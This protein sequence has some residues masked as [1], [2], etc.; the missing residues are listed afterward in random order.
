MDQTRQLNELGHCLAGV[1]QNR[2]QALENPAQFVHLRLWICPVVLFREDS[3]TFFME[4]ASASF[5]QPP[6]RQR[7]L[8]IRW[9]GDHLTAEYYALKQPQSFQGAAQATERLANLAES[10]LQPLIG[11]RLRVTSH[12]CTNTTRFEARQLPGEWCQF[13]I[14]GRVKYVELGFDAIAPTAR[15]EPAAFLMYDKGIDPENGKAIWGA[16]QGPFQLEK[17]EA[18]SI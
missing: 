10:D 6:Y 5:T 8:R 2:Q 18:L 15:Q 12:A 4:Q 9:L 1:F 16:L 13:T 3:H 17:I 14:E 7:L 11:S